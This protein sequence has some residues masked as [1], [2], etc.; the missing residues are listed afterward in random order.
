MKDNNKK[1]LQDI[2]KNIDHPNDGIAT[3][4]A[5]KIISM[6]RARKQEEDNLS[7]KFYNLPETVQ[8]SLLD[9]I[10]EIDWQE[11][12]YSSR[13]A[14]I[15]AYIDNYNNSNNN[16]KENPPFHDFK[17]IDVAV[18]S[19]GLYLNIMSEIEFEN[20]PKV[21]KA[22][23]AEQLGKILEAVPDG[24]ASSIDCNIKGLE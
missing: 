23:F 21:L 15:S 1:R 4:R 7:E 8:I 9:M 6:I 11:S 13:E 12:G 19:M 24:I 18:N 17:K 16:E 3:S 14:Q 20:D 22:Y 5:S 10:S 2:L